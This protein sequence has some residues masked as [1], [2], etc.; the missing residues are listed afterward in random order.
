MKN[1]CVY[2]MWNCANCGHTNPA[3]IG[4]CEECGEPRQVRY[5][6][7][8]WICKSCGHENDYNLVACENCGTWRT[9]SD[10]SDNVDSW[11][12]G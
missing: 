10:R 5:V 4:F 2:S 9:D 12:V 8:V 11:E 3:R 6:P 7:Q 1:C